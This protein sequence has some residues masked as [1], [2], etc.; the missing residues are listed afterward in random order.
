MS[1][2]VDAHFNFCQNSDQHSEVTFQFGIR[3]SPTI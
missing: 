2:T 1:R 3:I